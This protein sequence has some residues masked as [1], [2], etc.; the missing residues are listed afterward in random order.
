MKTIILF[1]IISMLFTT[2]ET[3]STLLLENSSKIIS[4]SDCAYLLYYDKCGFAKSGE[5]IK[6]VNNL[7][8]KRVRVTVSFGSRY[9]FDWVYKDKIYVLYAGES[10]YIGC[11]RGGMGDGDFSYNIVGCEIL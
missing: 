3:N 7:K 9:K 10:K 1:S 4:E 5:R 8:N 11:S 6:V 2:I